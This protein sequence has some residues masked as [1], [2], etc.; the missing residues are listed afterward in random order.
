LH[1]R[2]TGKLPEKRLAVAMRGAGC[3]SGLKEECCEC[4]IEF[5]TEGK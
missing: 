3:T 2:V 4:E 5:M 1:N